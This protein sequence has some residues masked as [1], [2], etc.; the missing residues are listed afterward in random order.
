MISK[1]LEVLNRAGI[2]ARPAA[3][4]AKTS[5]QFASDIFFEK[6]NMKINAKSI[7]GVITLGATYK[8]KLTCIVSGPDEKEAIEAIENLFQRRFE[9]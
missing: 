4:I 5:S 3:E 9:N 1:E 8:T 7:M 2:H 6:E